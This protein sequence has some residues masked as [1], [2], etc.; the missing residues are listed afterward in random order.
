MPVRSSRLIGPV[1]LAATPTA[2]FTVPVDE[3]W[4]IRAVRLHNFTGAA[5][6]AALRINGTSGADTVWAVTVPVATSLVDGNWWALPAGDVL[7]GNSDAAASV[8]V[9]IFG[10]KLAGVA[11]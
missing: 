10:A 6:V 2:L 3:T 4:V 8:A 9:T 5:R 7:Y 11:P 1:A